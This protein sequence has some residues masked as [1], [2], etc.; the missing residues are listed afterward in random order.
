MD[1]PQPTTARHSV[2]FPETREPDFQTAPA[3]TNRV[4]EF[5]FDFRQE[6]GW[7]LN[8]TTPAVGRQRVGD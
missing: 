6:R 7:H 2:P 3:Q 5:L 1:Q 4:G 8:L